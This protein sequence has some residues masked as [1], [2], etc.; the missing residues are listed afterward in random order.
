MNRPSSVAVALTIAAG[1]AYYY[2]KKDIDYRRREQAATGARPDEM[3][4]WQ[5]RVHRAEKQHGAASL[6]T[7]ATGNTPATAWSPQSS[8]VAGSGPNQTTR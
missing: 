3:L 6:G 5:D 8:S 7:Q 2:A 1:V 4:D